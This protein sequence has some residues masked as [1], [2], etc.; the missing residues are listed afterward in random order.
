M[1]VTRVI[2]WCRANAMQSAWGHEWEFHCR[3]CC[4][5]ELNLYHDGD[6]EYYLNSAHRGGFIPVN[7]DGV[8]CAA[9]GAAIGG[10]R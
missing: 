7:A 6:E 10:P 4:V 2:E 9:C 5:E 8:K 1:Q 3:T